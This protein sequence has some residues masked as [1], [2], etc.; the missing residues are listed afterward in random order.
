MKKFLMIVAALLVMFAA[1]DYFY[2]YNGG[3]YFPKDGKMTYFSK[4]EGKQLYIDE[5]DGF[6]VFDIRGVNMGLG[7]PGHFA[8]EAAVTKEEYLRWFGQIRDM[9]ANVVRIYTIGPEAFYDAFYEYNKENAEPLYLIHGVWV[10]DY[11]LNSS[12]G[13]LDEEFYQPFIEDCKAVVDVIHGRYKTRKAESIFP[14]KYDKDISKWVY[15]YLLGVEWEPTLVSYT[16]RSFEQLP[17]YQGKYFYTENARNFEVF[18]AATGDEVVSY[19]TEK[20]GS[21]RTVAFSNWPT[22]DPQEYPEAVAE[23]FSKSAFLDV[24]H[25]RTTEDFLPGQFASYHIYP[26]YPDYY[27]FFAEHE[28]NTYLQ[29]LQDI[30]AHHTMPVVISEFGVPSSRGMA[31]HEALGRNQGFMSETEQGEALISMYEDIKAA[32]SAGGIVFTW[33]DEWFK[34]TWNTMAGADLDMTAYWSNYQTNEQ[35]FGLLAFDP[36]EEDS[37][38]YVDGDKSDWSEED[39]VME[40]DG[41]RLSMKYDEKFI[42]F[43]VEKAGLDLKKDKLYLPVD[44]TPKSGA[45][46]AENFGNIAMSQPA[47]FI[48]ELDGVENSRVWVQEYYDMIEALYFEEIGSQNFFS[49]EFPEKD[50]EKFGQIR[51]FLQK[52]DYFEKADMSSEDKNDKRLAF[53]E[54]DRTNRLQYQVQEL[55]ETGKLTYGNADP[56]AKDFN[57]LADFCGGKGFVEIRL[58]WQL[59]NFADPVEMKIHDDYYENYGVE[60]LKI[61]E[62]QVGVGDGTETIEM[63]PFAL[64]K[65]G[66]KPAYHERLK[67]SY[68][69]LQE[70]WNGD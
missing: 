15:G 26:Y 19:E 23:Y 27:S 41:Y 28:E 64:E 70:Y 14:Q 50:S 7:K 52:Y 1:F 9:G 32:G 48:I 45:L 60:Y 55:Y 67:E 10:D 30:N 4:A 56:A 58:P 8:T 38:C 54:F 11:L 21:Q 17:Q 3:L 22:T 53:H 42:Y 46:K 62:M 68:Y 63:V 20:Y 66:K 47:D 51:L 49:K 40:Q 35:Y 43:L 34:R 29:Y 33:Q 59:L 18:L 13:A 25:I 36:G 44:T 65:L 61:D 16:D 37:I 5:G 39:R 12:Y 69:I 31:A 24:E 2:Y 6:E 57:S